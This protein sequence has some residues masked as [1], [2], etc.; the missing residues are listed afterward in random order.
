MNKTAFCTLFDRNY[1]TRG[2]TLMRSMREHDADAIFHVLCMDSETYELLSALGEP[3]THLVRLAALEAPEVLKVKPGRSIAEYCWTLTPVLMTYLLDAHPEVD[4][5]VYLDADIMFFSS[6][7]PLLDESSQASIT[8]IEHRYQEWNRDLLECGRFNVEWVGF[9]Q[10]AV[11]RACAARWRA[12]CLEWCYARVEDGRMGDQKYLDAWPTDFPSVH[13]LQHPGAGVAPWNF[14][15]HPIS[16]RGGAIF[17]GDAP[18]VFYHFHQLQLFEDGSADW[19]SETYANGRHRPALIYERYLLA[20]QASLE[21]ARAVAPSFSG[22]FVG[23]RKAKLRRWAQN[24]LPRWLKDRVK[25]L[26][27]R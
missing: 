23:G 17:I 18:L 8:I 5:F 1:L 2:L 12:E 10:N 14:T 9:R 25:A 21:S 24:R 4:E 11:G 7:Q 6:A 20:L 26:F 16:N 15:N 22:G 13:V 3:H 19:M 27:L